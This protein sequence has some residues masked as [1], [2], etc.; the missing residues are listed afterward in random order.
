MHRPKKK[1]ILVQSSKWWPRPKHFHV[2]W[3]GLDACHWSGPPGSNCSAFVASTFHCLVLLLSTHL[4]SSQY[5]ILI[6]TF[7]DLMHWWVEVL[8]AD[9]TTLNVCMWTAAEPRARAVATSNPFKPPPPS[10]PTQVIYYWPFQGGVPSAVY[11]IFIACPD[12]QA[13]LSLRWAHTHF[14]GFVMSQL[15]CWSSL[16]LPAGHLLGKSWPLGFPLVLFYFMPSFFVPFPCGVRGRKRNS[17]VSVP[18]HCLF[19]YFQ[20]ITHDSVDFSGNIK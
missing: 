7:A 1:S 17:I 4:V 9:R 10:T 6:C 13:D 12:A 19:I 3:L 20:P 11:S 16:G 5:W 15:I 14:V 2:S 8:H 18:D